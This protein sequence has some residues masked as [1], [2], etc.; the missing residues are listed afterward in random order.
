MHKCSSPL[1]FY[2]RNYTQNPL[3]SVNKLRLVS[4]VA[5]IHASTCRFLWC[6]YIYSSSQTNWA[7][8]P[9]LL[10][11]LNNNAWNS[12]LCRA[13]SIRHLTAHKCNLSFVPF[14]SLQRMGFLS[15]HQP[16]S[17]QGSL[18]ETTHCFKPHFQPSFR[19]ETRTRPLIN[20]E[21]LHSSFHCL[22][23]L[24]E[25][26]GVWAWLLCLSTEFFR[27]PQPAKFR[28]RVRKHFPHLFVA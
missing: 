16:W 12:D 25:P 13:S 17:F 15:H 9:A 26:S 5:D 18:Q 2:I 28:I 3:S 19:A 4:C 8:E 24:W 1:V 22:P 11:F 21:N 20:L 6:S 10:I 7:E 14:Y 27:S 23:F